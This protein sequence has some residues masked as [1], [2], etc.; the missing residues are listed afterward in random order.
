MTIANR[1]LVIAK[2]IIHV[3]VYKTYINNNA[4]IPMVVACKIEFIFS[5]RAYA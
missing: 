2:V 5:T 4:Q 1:W 3:I